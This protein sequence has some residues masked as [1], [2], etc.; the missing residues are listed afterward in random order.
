MS[1]NVV[2][3]TAISVVE[4]SDGS[5]SA[6][7]MGRQL[8]EFAEALERAGREYLAR[9]GVTP[10]DCHRLIVECCPKHGPGCAR[11]TYGALYDHVAWK[12]VDPAHLAATMLRTMLPSQVGA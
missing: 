7:V 4:G 3:Q 2:R 1:D 11:V 9:R 5:A 6:N 10:A 8:R 12:R